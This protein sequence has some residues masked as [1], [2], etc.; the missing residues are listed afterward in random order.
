MTKHQRLVMADP[1]WLWSDPIVLNFKRVPTFK[2]TNAFQSNEM[3]Y[4][5]NRR[6]S[7]PHWVAEK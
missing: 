3:K 4:K 6:E 2:E 1:E 5:W 7:A